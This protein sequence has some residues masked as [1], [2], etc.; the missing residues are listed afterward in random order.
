MR[1]RRLAEDDGPM[2]ADNRRKRWEPDVDQ[3]GSILFQNAERI[4]HGRSDVGF[5]H[6]QELVMRHAEPQPLQAPLKC[7]H[8][9]RGRCRG[10]WLDRG[11]RGPP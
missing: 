3:R 2:G 9:N 8:D 1:G 4:L 11:D 10:A 6:R 5:H 7:G